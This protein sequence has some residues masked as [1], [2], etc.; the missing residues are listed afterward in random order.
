[1]HKENGLIQKA[2]E[3][4]KKISL[5]PFEVEEKLKK[6]KMEKGGMTLEVFKSDKAEKIIFSSIEIYEMRVTEESVIVWPGDDY[7]FPVFWCNLTKMPGMNIA[8]IDYIPLMD[9][10]IWPDY[11]A[12]NLTGFQEI[13]KDIKEELKDEIQEEIN[14]LSS[15]VIWA[16]SP[17]RMIL[18]LTDKG[19]LQFISSVKQLCKNYFS[20]IDSAVATEGD[21]KKFSKRKKEAV[22]KLMKENDP[23]YPIMIG[24]F[25]EELTGKV[26]DIIF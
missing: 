10:T 21:E 25:G 12:Q 5:K 11:A 24:A 3:V 2:M 13:K 19:A 16:L 20:I 8:I 6:I 17:Y 15:I 7:N 1:M 22:R 14:E 23:G 18:K 9:L 26:F 4:F